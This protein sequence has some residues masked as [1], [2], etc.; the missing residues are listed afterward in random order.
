[1]I[2]DAGTG[3]VDLLGFSMGS[4]VAAAVAAL[5]PD[6]VHRLVLVAGWAACSG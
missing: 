5:R 3:P 4:P 2:E 1:M 6:L